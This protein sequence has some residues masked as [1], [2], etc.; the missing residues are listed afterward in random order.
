MALPADYLWL[1]LLSWRLTAIFLATLFCTLG[2]RRSGLQ[3]PDTPLLSDHE[4]HDARLPAAQGQQPLPLG[5]SRRAVGHDAVKALHVN[6]SQLASAVLELMCEN[7]KVKAAL[8]CNK[9]VCFQ[10]IGRCVGPVWSCTDYSHL[11]AVQDVDVRIARFLPLAPGLPR[12][13]HRKCCSP[14]RRLQ[15][16]GGR[17]TSIAAMLSTCRQTPGGGSHLP[18]QRRRRRLLS[19]RR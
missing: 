2:S 8:G 14:I 9:Y 4:G 12:R 6:G 5:E 18:V 7:T 17:R 10:I 1:L 3:R 11:K 13:L 15:G 16:R 19:G